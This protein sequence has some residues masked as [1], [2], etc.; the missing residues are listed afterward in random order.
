[1]REKQPHI[2]DVIFVL[3]LFGLFALSALAIILAGSR[4]YQNTVDNMQT[5]YETRTTTSYIGEKIRQ[6]ISASC[7]TVSGQDVIVIKSVMADT[8][9]NT[10]LY[11]HEGY[12]RELLI[13]ADTEFTTKLFPAGQKITEVKAISV[14]EKDDNILEINIHQKDGIINSMLINSYSGE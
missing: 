7:I 13:S 8:D 10:Y 5:N 6:G 12:L 2:V 4:I 3:T 11:T 9:Y 14:A 1:M